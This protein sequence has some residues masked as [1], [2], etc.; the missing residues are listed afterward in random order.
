MDTRLGVIA[1]IAIFGTGIAACYIVKSIVPLALSVA[2]TA[3]CVILSF[4]FGGRKPVLSKTEWRYFPLASKT[5]VS[6]NTAIYRFKL[7]RPDDVLGLPVGQHISVGVQVDGREISRSYT[8]ISSDVNPGHFDLLVKSYP[9]GNVSRVIGAM[10]VGELI[11]VRGPKGNFVYKGPNFVR[12]FGMI[13][14]GTGITPML[15][16]IQAVLNNPADVTTIQLLYA[17]VSSDDILLKHELDALAARHPRFRV[18]YILNNPPPA[19]PG[20]VGFVTKDMIRD[21]CP[22]PASDIKL[23]MCGP[24]PMVKMMEMYTSELGYEKTRVVS[25]LHDMVFRF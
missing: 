11:K 12:A 22:P 8:P 25:Q 15:Q 24:P 23:L 21:L 16:I 17:N 10:Q 4:A 18:Y 13:A 1:P 6:A 20:G 3:S 7:P 2:L 19:W 14:G 5:P 9:A